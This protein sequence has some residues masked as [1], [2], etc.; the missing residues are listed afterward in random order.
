MFTQTQLRG[1][2]ENIFSHP[3]LMQDHI[4]LLRKDTAESLPHPDSPNFN[5]LKVALVLELTNH[6][7]ERVGRPSYAIAYDLNMI[8]NAIL[9]HKMQDGE[10]AFHLNPRLAVTSWIKKTFPRH[11][12]LWKLLTI[13]K[14]VAK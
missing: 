7:R 3:M 10:F 4:P 13:T 12:P 9:A 6:Y 8:T 2:T 1:D 14:P 5:A 11:H